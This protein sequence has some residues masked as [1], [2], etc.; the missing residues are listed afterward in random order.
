LAVHPS[1]ARF[2]CGKLARHFLSD[3]PPPTL[4]NA[5]AA[6]WARSQGQTSDVMAV[7]LNSPEFS[8]PATNANNS[9]FKDPMHFV[10]SAVR[11]CYG[12][13]VVLNTGP[14]V[15]WLNR[16]GQG[17][18]NRASPDG[19]PS[20][21][22]AWSSSGQLATRLEI[23]RI[24]GG[25]SAGLFKSEDPAVPVAVREVPAF[26]QLARPIY[27]QAVRALLAEPTRQALDNAG[28]PQDWNALYLSAPEFMYC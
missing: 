6:A 24:L 1:T 2:V 19:Y 28:S 25:G 12:E 27:W 18:Y 16:M 21:A 17:L 5:M 8:A 14:M 23:A 26:P 7:L 11:A 9:K 10:V 15:V 4:V 22:A 13:R 20:G 3:T